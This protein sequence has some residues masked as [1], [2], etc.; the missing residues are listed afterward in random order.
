L[1]SI[2]KASCPGYKSAGNQAIQAYYTSILFAFRQHFSVSAVM[3]MI[4]I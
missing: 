4:R 3:E 1:L 2:Q